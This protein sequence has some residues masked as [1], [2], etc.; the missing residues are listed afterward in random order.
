MREERIRERIREGRDT[1]D[2]VT[3]YRCSLLLL[4]TGIGAH[5]FPVPKEVVCNLTLADWHIRVPNTAPYARAA[6]YRESYFASRDSFARR[7]RPVSRETKVS[8]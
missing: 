3:L 2:P 6:K 5:Q 7:T 8:V 4:L 1:A